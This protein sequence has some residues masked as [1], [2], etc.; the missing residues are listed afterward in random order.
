MGALN[1]KLEERTVLRMGAIF[2]GQNRQLKIAPGCMETTLKHICKVALKICNRPTAWNDR[3][4]A[5]TVIELWARP[6]DLPREA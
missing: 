6:V 5:G 3:K 2:Q 4:Q 1:Q